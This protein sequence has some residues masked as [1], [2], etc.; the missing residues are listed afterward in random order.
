MHY[1]GIVG[2]NWHNLGSLEH[3]IASS[4]H[5]ACYGLVKGSSKLAGIHFESE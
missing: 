3:A 4:C 5:D 1:A 2:I